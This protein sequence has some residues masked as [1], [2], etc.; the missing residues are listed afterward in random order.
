[1]EKKKKIKKKKKD[2]TTSSTEKGFE[3]LPCNHS[4][5]KPRKH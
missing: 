5:L 1:M 2:K 3:A 4:I